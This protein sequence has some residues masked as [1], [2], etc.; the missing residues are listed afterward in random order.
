LETSS[1]DCPG[2]LGAVERIILNFILRKWDVDWI[3]PSDNKFQWRALM[4]K[5]IKHPII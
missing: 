4:T 3:K 5:T 1:I 2:D